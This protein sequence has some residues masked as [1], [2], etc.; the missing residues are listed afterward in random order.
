MKEQPEAYC[1]FVEFLHD[2]CEATRPTQ[3]PFWE[4]LCVGSN[5]IQV[6][7]IAHQQLLQQVF[8]VAAEIIALR[9]EKATLEKHH[10]SHS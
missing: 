3:T 9:R 4:S 5:Q 8:K 6:P 2:I 1:T 7:K 10:W